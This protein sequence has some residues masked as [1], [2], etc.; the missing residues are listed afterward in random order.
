MS[1]YIVFGTVAVAYGLSIYYFLPLAMLSFNFQLVLQIFFFILVGMLFGLSLLAF[2]LQ[3]F[4]EIILTQVLFIWE[5]KSMRD[6]ITKNLA[7]HK[8]R[9]K[10]TS[11]IYSLALGFII[12]LIVSYNLQIKTTQ[13]TALQKEGAYLKLNTMTQTL[14]TPGQFDPVMRANADLVEGFSYITPDLKNIHQ[15]HSS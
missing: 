2:N 12:F 11:I 3:R 1:S 6:M 4:L 8:M 13:L 15:A 7:A 5:K 14:L 10:M 9:N